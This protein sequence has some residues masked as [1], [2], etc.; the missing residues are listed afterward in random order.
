MA[1]RLGWA[2]FAFG[3]VRV[4]TPSSSWALIF[5]WSILLDRAKDRA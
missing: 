4:S 5:S 2:C 3:K 1:I